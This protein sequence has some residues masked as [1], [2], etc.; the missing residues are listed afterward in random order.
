MQI[1]RRQVVLAGVGLGLAFI[2][3]RMDSVYPTILM[4]SCFNAIA[5]VLAV[6]VGGD[7]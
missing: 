5:L 3:H 2:R 4:H 6:T 1:G 7:S